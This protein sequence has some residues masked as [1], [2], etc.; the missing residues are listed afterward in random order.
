MKGGRYAKAAGAV[1]DS[2]HIANF[3][4]VT[5]KFALISSGSNLHRLDAIFQKAGYDTLSPT[6]TLMRHAGINVTHLA[7]ILRNE[8]DPKT[9]ILKGNGGDMLFI[10]ARGCPVLQAVL[11]EV[12]NHVLVPGK[13][14][15][16][17]IIEDV[18]FTAFYYECVLQAMG[19][20][21]RVYHSSL[22]YKERDDL[23]ASFK[24]SD[25]NSVSVLIL[26]Y[27]VGS[28]GLNLDGACCRV[29]IA[30][31]AESHGKEEQAAY[32]VVRVTTEHA[33][34]TVSR[35][36][37]KNT[38]HD[39]RVSRQ[40][41][42][43]IP[44]LASRSFDPAHVAAMLNALQIEIQTAHDSEEGKEIREC[45]DLLVNSFTSQRR[46][47]IAQD[48]VDKG[49]STD[50][51][52]VLSAYKLIPA[53]ERGWSSAD[54][55]FLRQLTRKQYYEQWHKLSSTVKPLFSHAK[56]A[57]R[58][59][60]TFDPNKTYKPSDV[61]VAALTGD[62]VLLERAFESLLKVKISGK[63]LLHKPAPHIDFDL[64]PEGAERALFSLMPDVRSQDLDDID[65]G[66]RE[67]EE[68]EESG[69]D[70]EDSSF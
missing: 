45:E 48:L 43:M 27:R 4:D 47:D 66:W 57:T 53:G 59:L 24:S 60:L 35:V 58:R 68:A 9:T 49:S 52:E 61:E 29:L 26:M 69:Q 41:D 40:V 65:N 5:R 33:K 50:R 17:L 46:E 42:R 28:F 64:L 62:G 39:Y 1:I 70:D 13:I 44:D 38:Y 8:E 18:P 16:I 3:T 54:G 67:D 55:P 25:E 19:I 32:R 34:I 10:L 22:T 31:P 6:V 63:N 30:S 15:K 37:T 14:E 56:N 21:A 51:V 20:K 11:H 7:S 12:R 23:K 2:S 36:H